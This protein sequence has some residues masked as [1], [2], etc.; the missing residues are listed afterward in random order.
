[1]NGKLG[2]KYLYKDLESISKKHLTKPEVYKNT[3][4]VIDHYHETTGKNKNINYTSVSGNQSL[5]IKN[6]AGST[7]KI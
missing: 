5:T 3:Q 4:K 6:Y 1:M 2:T 7:T